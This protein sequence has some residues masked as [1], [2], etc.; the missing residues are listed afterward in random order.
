MQVDFSQY[1]IE[2]MAELIGFDFADL[3]H[4]ARQILDARDDSNEQRVR[5]LFAEIDCSRIGE[6]P[7]YEAAAQA[8]VAGF[9]LGA[10][11][12]EMV[13]NPYYEDLFRRYCEGCYRSPRGD[14]YR[15]IDMRRFLGLPPNPK[16]S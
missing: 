10:L 16:V 8:W 2:K 13:G 6:E 4:R 12:H 11:R 15:K 14:R 3:K 9:F 7:S 1:Q 5:E